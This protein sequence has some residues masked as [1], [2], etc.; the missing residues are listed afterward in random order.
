METLADIT[1][2]FSFVA[3]SLIYVDAPVEGFVV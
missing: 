3:E 1:A 2:R